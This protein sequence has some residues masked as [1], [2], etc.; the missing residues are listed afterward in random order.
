[1]KQKVDI[2][3]HLD[4]SGFEKHKA[5]AAR[6]LGKP[7]DDLSEGDFI[8]LKYTFFITYLGDIAKR[9]EAVGNIC[10]DPAIVRSIDCYQLK[11]GRILVHEI[12]KKMDRLIK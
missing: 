7:I 6:V 12:L 4:K 1:M 9:L 11:E 10:D 8:K 3:M 2:C 5:D